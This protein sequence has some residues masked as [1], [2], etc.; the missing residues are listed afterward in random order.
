MFREH[1]GSQRVNNA[2]FV[3]T[4]ERNNGA[5]ILPPDIV[6]LVEPGMKL[7]MSMVVERVGKIDDPE[8]QRC[9]AC[10]V[11]FEGVK[12]RLEERMRWYLSHIDIPVA[13]IKYC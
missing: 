9:P 1:P 8:M 2:T 12:V 3:L 4:D 7:A 13:S 10:Q 11:K 5:L 6:K